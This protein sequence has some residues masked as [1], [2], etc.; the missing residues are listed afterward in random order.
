MALITAVSGCRLNFAEGKTPTA[1]GAEKWKGSLVTESITGVALEYWPLE[2]VS[3]SPGIMTR[4]S[5]GETNATSSPRLISSPNCTLECCVKPLPR[6][7]RLASELQQLNACGSTELTTGLSLPTTMIFC[8][9]LAPTTG[10][11]SQESL[12]Y[13]VNNPGLSARSDGIVTSTCRRSIVLL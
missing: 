5:L 3:L 13:A 11:P 7:T 9:V 12:A 4:S 1:T 10:L 2:S 6:T 8:A